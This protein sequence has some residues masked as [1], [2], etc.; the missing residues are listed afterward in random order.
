M[1]LRRREVLLWFYLDVWVSP[2]PLWPQT[3][4]LYSYMAEEP[5]S[6]ENQPDKT[7]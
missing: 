7:Q 5:E 3:V 1:M 4:S 6:D 2:L